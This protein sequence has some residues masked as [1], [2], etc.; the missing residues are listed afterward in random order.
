MYLST[1]PL[2]IKM[3]LRRRDFDR[4]RMA[5][6]ILSSEDKENLRKVR[7]EEQE[8]SLKAAEERREEFRTAAKFHLNTEEDGGHPTER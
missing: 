1:S 2:V 7:A 3:T 6:Q 8:Q 4:I 5:A